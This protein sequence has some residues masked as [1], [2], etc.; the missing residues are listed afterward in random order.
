LPRGDRPGSI[1]H[2]HRTRTTPD[3]LAGAA[4]PSMAIGGEPAPFANAA[5]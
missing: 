4:A 1:G 5:R 2:R 3:A